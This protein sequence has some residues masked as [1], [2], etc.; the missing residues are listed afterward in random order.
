MWAQPEKHFWLIICHFQSVL[1]RV[2]SNSWDILVLNHHHP[3]GLKL[4]SYYHYLLFCQIVID[5]SL[6]LFGGLRAF[7]SLL[8]KIW[9]SETAGNNLDRFLG[10]VTGTTSVSLYQILSAL[11]VVRMRHLKLI[12]Y[13]GGIV[14]SFSVEVFVYS[15]NPF[16]A[17]FHESLTFFVSSHR[18]G[19][20][21]TSVQETAK[22]NWLRLQE[23]N[24]HQLLQFD[25][26]PSLDCTAQIFQGTVCMK[27]TCHSFN[28]IR[29]NV[30][31]S[32]G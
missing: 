30:P 26:G 5:D 21:R 14:V 18:I 19:W 25:I 10:I 9:Y 17:G 32:G 29:R 28:S 24:F 7:V 23:W 31:W 11:W 20:S 27:A 12:T 2:C 22:A 13:S 6:Y 15:A 16:A 8:I 3:E 4:L 1:T